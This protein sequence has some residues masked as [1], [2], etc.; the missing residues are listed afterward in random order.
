MKIIII[1]IYILTHKQKTYI[2]K[3]TYTHIHTNIHTRT[4]I[5]KIYSHYKRTYVKISVICNYIVAYMQTKKHKHKD[6]KLK[7]TYKIIYTWTM[8]TLQT[9]IRKNSIICNYVGTYI[10]TKSQ[11]YNHLHLFT[12]HKLIYTNKHL[13]KFFITHTHVRT[14]FYYKF[15]TSY[16]LQYFYNE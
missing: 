8:Y 10:Q 13:Y 1:F 4:S 12:S 2:H 11:S 14:F 16:F 7:H 3:D 9:K 5:L 6:H 15:R